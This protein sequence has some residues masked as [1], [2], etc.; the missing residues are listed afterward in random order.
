MANLFSNRPY[1][2]VPPPRPINALE[3]YARIA[4]ALNVTPQPKTEWVNGYY[5]LVPN[6]LFGY[7]YEWVPG[8]WRS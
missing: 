6:G 2:W 7:R 8:Y 3:Q 5:R 1:R 4:N